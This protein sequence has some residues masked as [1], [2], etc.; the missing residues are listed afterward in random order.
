MLHW[1]FFCSGHVN[2]TS[3]ILACSVKPNSRITSRGSVAGLRW[4]LHSALP[5]NVTAVATQIPQDTALDCFSPIF[6]SVK[7]RNTKRR[8]NRH[9]FG[10]RDVGYQGTSNGTERLVG[11]SQ[12]GKSSIALA[13]SVI[14][15]RSAKPSRAWAKVG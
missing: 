6:P 10:Q 8:K 5:L 14:I 2:E 15:F 7:H 1:I 13:A 3:L 9:R 4:I 11:S 12:T